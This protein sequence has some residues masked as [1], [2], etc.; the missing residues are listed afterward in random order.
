MCYFGEDQFKNA[1]P[2]D[3]STCHPSIIPKYTPVQVLWEQFKH[4]I[5][6]QFITKPWPLLTDEICS[7]CGNVPNTRGC[8][9]VRTELTING[10]IVTVDHSNQVESPNGDAK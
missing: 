8:T 1:T 7:A 10:Q 4:V 6:F 2:Y 5:L 9:K 3:E